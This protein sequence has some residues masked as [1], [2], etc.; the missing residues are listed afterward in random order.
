MALELK[1][2]RRELDELDEEIVKLYEKRIGLCNL[3]AEYKKTSGKNVLD[4][5]REKQKLENVK[6]LVDDE[7]VKKAAEELYKQIMTASR[8][9]QYRLLKDR[10]L[11]ETQKFV[12]I[13]QLPKTEDKSARIVYQGVEGAYSHQ[14]ALAYF[15]MGYD[16]FHEDTFEKAVERVE[17]GTADY[18][19]IPIENSTAGYVRDTYNLLV[20]KDVYITDEYFQSIDHALLGIKGAKT[21]DIKKVYSH[22]QA[23]MQCAEYIKKHNFEA[24][25]YLN[26]ATSAVRIKEEADA[27]KAAI[28]GKAAAKKYGLEILDE[29]I[30]E[31]KENITRF[32]ILA[33][34]PMY[35][36]NSKKLSLMFELRHEAGA[37]YDVLGNIIFNGLNMLNIESVPIKDKAW[38]YRFFVDVEGNLSDANIKNML[39][40]M[41]EETL[42]LKILG[43]Y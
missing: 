24:V 29:G 28:A 30:S 6:S 39:S 7:Y 35:K 41:S 16:I 34:K 33:K 43:N 17:D 3:V 37:L 23:L 2:I 21:E 15:G 20:D 4:K 10:S 1:D 19:V 9:Q 36:E 14:T 42:R 18:A 27:S 40:G 26:T 12:Q 38:E 31:V 25:A 22:P 8:R 32:V 5:E 13:R 11:S